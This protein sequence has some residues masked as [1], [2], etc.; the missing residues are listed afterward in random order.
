MIPTSFKSQHLQ[1]PGQRVLVISTDIKPLQTQVIFR[2]LFRPSVT[3]IAFPRPA[4]VRVVRHIHPLN[5]GPHA[6]FV[7]PSQTK[8]LIRTPTTALVEIHTILLAQRSNSN[9]PIQRMT[10][11]NSLRVPRTANDTNHAI[12]QGTPGLGRS[13]V[14]VPNRKLWARS[15]H[16]A[17]PFSPQVATSKAHLLQATPFGHF[18]QNSLQCLSAAPAF[19]HSKYNNNL[20]SSVKTMH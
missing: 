15:L 10:S 14:S 5:Q 12:T 2:I 7:S 16:V 20:S 13:G 9:H 8:S 17:N 11:Q 1:D 18:T 6:S 3:F 4:S 19:T